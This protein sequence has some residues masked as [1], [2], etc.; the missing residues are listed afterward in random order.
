MIFTESIDNIETYE[1]EI[2]MERAMSESDLACGL[3]DIMYVE[4]GDDE[5][6]LKSFINKIKDAIKK[7]FKSFREWLSSIIKKIKGEITEKLSTQQF[8]DFLNNF[9][10]I[11]ERA[12]KKG[13]KKFKFFDI[14]KA[15]NCYYLETNEYAKILNDF[16]VYKNITKNKEAILKLPEKV[17][18]IRETYEEKLL[19][20]LNEKR[21]YNIRDA[22]I[23]YTGL[24]NIRLMKAQ[25]GMDTLDYY[26]DASKKIEDML[27]KILSGEATK[28]LGENVSE[29]VKTAEKTLTTTSQNTVKRRNTIVKAVIATAVASGLIGLGAVKIAKEIKNYKKEEREN[30]ERDREFR[31]KIGNR[32][33]DEIMRDIVN[34]KLQDLID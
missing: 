31:E 25:Y 23:I 16:A 30:A 19:K 18:K 5:G 13:I 4:S 9:E 12:E 6:K 1:S 22:K 34:K 8:R 14:D 20:I 32:S 15:W 29:V 28:D 33:Q 24:N 21:E 7:F 26:E 10:D 3:F 11:V 2:M 17:D 27:E